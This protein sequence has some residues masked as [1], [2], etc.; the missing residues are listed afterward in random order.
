MSLTSDTCELT[1]CGTRYNVGDLILVFSVLSQ[2]SISGVITTISGRDIIV[3]CGSG[4]RFSFLLGQLRE[5]RVTI[6]KDVSSVEASQ[7]VNSMSCL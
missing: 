4:A 7:L 5:G 1:V 2:E 3:R 6:S